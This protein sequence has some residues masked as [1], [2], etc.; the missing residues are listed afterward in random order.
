MLLAAPA[1]AAPDL[2]FR[3]GRKLDV[4]IAKSRLNWNTWKFQPIGLSVANIYLWDFGDSKLSDEQEP[5]HS[6]PRW[7][8]YKVTLSVSDSAGGVGSAEA[9]I[10]VS[11]W[12]IQNI[13]L[14]GILGFL[15]LCVVVLILLII[16][17]KLPKFKD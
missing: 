2:G 8:E 13:W 7:G 12:H 14:Q 1:H 10:A 17:N 6:W 16:F 9:L 4:S 3:A 5:V 11:F 15:G